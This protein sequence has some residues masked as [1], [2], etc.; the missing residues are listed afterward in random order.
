VILM[1]QFKAKAVGFEFDMA[2]KQIEKRHNGKPEEGL[3]EH[4]QRKGRR[5]GKFA[6]PPAP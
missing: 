1:S 2:R 6:E 5:I 4:D 3:Q